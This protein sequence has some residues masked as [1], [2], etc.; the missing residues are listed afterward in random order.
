MSNI[1]KLLLVPAIHHILNK[2][3]PYEKVMINENQY[4]IIHCRF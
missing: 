4:F 1:S 2:E 3:N